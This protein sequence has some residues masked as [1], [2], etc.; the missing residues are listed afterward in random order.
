MSG[1]NP[2]DYYYC[3][4]EDWS[5]DDDEDDASDVW[6]SDDDDE[7]CRAMELPD[8]KRLRLEM[9]E[10]EDVEQ[11]GGALFDFD[12]RQG[13]M[14]RRWKNVVNKTCHT[15]RL[16]QLREPTPTDRLGEAL[17]DALRRALLKA[18]RPESGVTDED[19]IHFTMQATAF[20]AGS[21]HCFQS[22]QFSIGEVR[23]GEERFATYLQQLARQLN[24]SQSFSPGDD[25]EMD[26]TT[27]RMPSSGSRPRK[28]DPAKALVRNIVK[29]SRIKIK[30][31][32]DDLCCAR[33]IVTMRAYVDEKS[34]LLPTVAYYSLR[35]GRP[36]QKNQAPQ[37][38][39]EAGVGEGPC[40]FNELA[41]LQAV[42]PSYQLKVLQI[43][44]PHMIVF[45]GP[46][47][48]RKILLLLE[49]NHYDGC[50]SYKAWLNTNYYCHDCDRGY[51]TEDMEHHPCHGKWCRS[52]LSSDCNDF[53]RLKEAMAPGEYPR[54]TLPC[55]H[56]HRHFYGAECYAR[57]IDQLPHEPS[58]CRS[59]RKCPECAKVD[60]VKFAK[61]GRAKG[62][63]HKCGWADC[64]HCE[65]RVSLQD[66]QCYIQRLKDDVDERKTKKVPDNTVGTRGI[67]KLHPG[68]MAEVERD[69]PLFCLRG[70]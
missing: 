68:N 45:A 30:N 37:L 52:C 9:S 61:N 64:P 2:L 20:A 36:A 57:H 49:D 60:Q 6:D 4:E 1:I 69:P 11:E 63:R 62:P 66:H 46:P 12:L 43:D 29:K 8:A 5:D 31:F 48:L 17:T 34:G 39:Q 18:I 54:P 67:V 23:G 65:K 58:T 47:Q 7:W 24:S 19:R 59:L 16:Q 32:D 26:I 14:L 55:D 51:N 22:T 38:M 25:F 10:E 53:K 13:A 56:C 15:A 50:T 3:E 44:R 35:R 28:Y 27:I 21:N 40:G 70:L 41:K 33:A 42:L